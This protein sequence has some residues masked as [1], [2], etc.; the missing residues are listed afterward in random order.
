MDNQ[1]IFDNS[2][3]NVGYKVFNLKEISSIIREK[4]KKIYNKSIDL[5]INNFKQ[6]RKNLI[7]LNKNYKFKFDRLKFNF[8][9][10]KVLINIKRN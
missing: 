5:K 10:E 1:K 8:E 2:V 7:I 3:S 9:I 6:K 4:Y